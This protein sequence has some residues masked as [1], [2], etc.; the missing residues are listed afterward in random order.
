MFPAAFANNWVVFC[1]S[2]LHHDSSQSKAVH[3]AMKMSSL[4]G[5]SSRDAERAG[6]GVRAEPV[7][8]FP[9]S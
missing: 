1:W 2:I 3:N 4:V 6:K 5:L 9:L 7:A 8:G